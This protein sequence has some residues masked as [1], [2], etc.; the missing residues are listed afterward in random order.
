ML[1]SWHDSV[2]F[3]GNPRRVGREGGTK[4]VSRREVFFHPPLEQD[5]LQVVVQHLPTYV[6]SAL[7]FM[8]HSTPIKLTK[9]L[10]NNR[11]HMPK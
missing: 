10:I 2:F 11:C 1:Q 6:T 9:K 3:A 7:G 4:S 5:H 8:C